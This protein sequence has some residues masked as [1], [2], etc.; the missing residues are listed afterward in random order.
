MD[1]HHTAIPRPLAIW[2]GNAVFL[3]AAL[4]L[5]DVLA[6]LGLPGVLVLHGT[7]ARAPWADRYFDVALWVLVG[8]TMMPSEWAL[9]CAYV[10]YQMEQLTSPWM[11]EQ[12]VKGLAGALQ[13]WD[14]APKHVESWR[15]MGLAA[16]YVPLTPPLAWLGDDG[17]EPQHV[18]VLFYGLRNDRRERLRDL[19]AASLSHRRICFALDFD[20]FGEARDC[21]VRGAKVV[22]NVHF[23]PT[24]ALE[25]HRINFL[26]A[27]RKCVVSELSAD[28]YLDGRYA[29]AVVFT[30]T[31]ALAAAI[32]ALL[33]D[34]R[35]R[36]DLEARASRFAAQLPTEAAAWLAPTLFE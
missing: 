14:F 2:A 1:R 22:L 24:A 9:P 27:R 3:E 10:V 30:H 23:Y 28:A 33:A 6:L 17:A 29:E 16:S 32:E 25:V 13:V 19:L 4:G 35:R 12:Y 7:A 8:L 34:E 5:R 21:A 18:D 15:A 11:T 20:L 26:L 31:T 36:R